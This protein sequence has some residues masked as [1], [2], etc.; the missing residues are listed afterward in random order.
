MATINPTSPHN[1]Y[2][3]LL[4]AEL[5]RRGISHKDFAEAFGL[6]PSNLSGILNGKRKIPVFL[7]PIVAE[8]L[9]TPAA[10]IINSQKNNLS[11][12]LL[13]EI[14]SSDELVAKTE[15]E[16]FEK[17]VCLKSLLK[18][19][20]SFKSTAVE[21]LR[22]LK[23]IY[24]LTSAS[25]LLKSS[26]RLTENCFRKSDKTGLNYIMIT[27]WVVKTKSA[28]K[29]PNNRPKTSFDPTH[30]EQLATSMSE[31]LHANIDNTPVKVKEL[32]NSYGIG[33]LEVPKEEK[34]SIDGYSFIMDGVP[35]IAVTRRFDRIDNYAFSLM[36]EL[37][38][39]YHRHIDETGKINIALPISESSEN[40][41]SQE[42]EADKFATE[43]LIPNSIW[44]LAPPVPLNPYA[45]QKKYTQWAQSKHLNPW[46]VLG[47]ISHE[48]GMY[49]FT[50]DASRTINQ[51]KKGVSMTK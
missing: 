46:I 40:I 7:I 3:S 32:L 24:G 4:K 36:H 47:R 31:L 16:A 13:S 21:R 10:D 44:F 5:E 35:F 37:G 20:V 19:L 27:T 25:D 1:G 49:R 45:I 41:L 39:I 14:D 33:Y 51:G 30:I 28:A 15:L 29:D 34:A 38:H 50:S 8:M 23:E 26:Q 17:V 2:G 48:T 6:K 22:A 12:S 43:K 11:N 18:G 42:E 9:G